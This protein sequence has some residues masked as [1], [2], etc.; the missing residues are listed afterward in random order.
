MASETDTSGNIISPALARVLQLA[1]E[2]HAESQDAVVFPHVVHFAFFCFTTAF[3]VD[4]YPLL[5][6]APVP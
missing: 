5:P 1:N 3:S 2:V 6:T 4:N